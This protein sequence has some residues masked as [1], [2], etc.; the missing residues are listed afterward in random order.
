MKFLVILI[1]LIVNHFWLGRFDRF[2]DGWFFRFRRLADRLAAGVA[3]LRPLGWLVPLLAVYG[4]PLLLL[5]LL[6]L[7]LEGRGL[8]IPTMLAH[9]LVLLVAFD[10]T[11]PGRLARRFLDKW[12]GDDLEGC[13]LYLRSELRLTGDIEADDREGLVRFFEKQ[14]AYRWFEKMF[15]VFFWYMLAGPMGV[16][17]CYVSYQLRDSRGEDPPGRRELVAAAVGLLEWAP[18]RLLGLTLCLAGNFVR[19]F[20]RVKDGFWRFGG[21]TDSASALHGYASAALHGLTPPEE[22]GEPASADDGAN[23]AGYL[24]R[25][26]RA[27]Q[28]DALHALLLRSQVIWLGA[29]AL[30]TILLEF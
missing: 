3:G 13:A 5:G 12:R 18:L 27:R 8:G 17:V 4:L 10:R 29:F 9:I 6:L 11:Q 28:T 14:L 30:L 15:V 21:G 22:E 24:A 25:A 20:E 19:C 23:A 2:D 16:A 7:A 1:C 26:A